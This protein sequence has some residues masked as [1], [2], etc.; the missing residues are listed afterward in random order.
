MRTRTSN[1][2]VVIQYTDHGNVR[3]IDSLRTPTAKLRQGHARRAMEEFIAAADAEGLTLE[4]GAS[5]LNKSTSLGRLVRFYESLG[6]RQTGRSVNPAGHPLMRRAPVASTVERLYASRADVPSQLGSLTVPQANYWG[7]IYDA[8]LARDGDTAKAARIAWFQTRARLDRYGRVPAVERLPAGQAEPRGEHGPVSHE[9][10]VVR[11]HVARVRRWAD[12]WVEDW[13][14]PR[15]DNEAGGGAVETREDELERMRAWG[16]ARGLRFLGAGVS[17]AVYALDARYVVKFAL[18][19]TANMNEAA[20]WDAAPPDV[21]KFLMPVVDS[22]GD[23]LIMA[24]APGDG[25]HTNLRDASGRL[26]VIVPLAARTRLQQFG[27]EDIEGH[28]TD[29]FST[30]GR[31]LDYGEW[32]PRP[33][34]VERLR[35]EPLPTAAHS[36]AS[37]TTAWARERQKINDDRMPIMLPIDDLVRVR[38]YAWTRE[39]AR[40]SPAEWDALVESMR[41]HGWDPK[42][43]AH[44]MVGKDGRAKLG[45]GNH[46]LAIARRLGI[47]EVPVWVHFYTSVDGGQRVVGPE[48]VERMGLAVPDGVVEFSARWSPVGTLTRAARGEDLTDDLPGIERVRDARDRAYARAREAIRRVGNDEAPVERLYASRADLPPQLGSLTVPQANY[49]SKVYDAVKEREVD[50]GASDREAGGKAAAI[51]WY[52]TR[53]RLAEHGRVPSV[54]RMAQTRALSPFERG[55]L[56]DLGFASDPEEIDLDH[57]WR[58]VADDPRD[59]AAHI[60][61]KRVLTGQWHC[62][63]R[64][65]D[66]LVRAG[67]HPWYTVVEVLREVDPT[68]EIEDPPKPEG[69]P[70]A[71]DA[72]AVERMAATSEPAWLDLDTVLAAVPAAAANGVSEVARSRRGFVAAYR[73]ADGDPNALARDGHSGQDWRARRNAFV[74]RH[75]AQGDAEGYWSGGAPTRRHLALVMWAYSP[76]PKRLRAWLSGLG[77]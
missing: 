52:Q 67:V 16:E 28:R 20:A 48:E 62:H 35:G 69:M 9:D 34:R 66:A 10:P 4:L 50:A 40:N 22:D 41:V 42:R 65:V 26:R 53:K 46:R 13:V 1:A 59:Y 72:F 21:R 71:R 33:E 18:D 15:D 68:G 76:D 60:V 7:R 70:E 6:F 73:D 36:V 17:R 31:V 12:E 49:W 74:A 75:T 3:T 55:V 30:D 32:W 63:G 11:A 5:P 14:E 37:I 19:P 23:W 45:E 77:R 57:A 27:I 8:V 58:H 29:N 25:R 2:G 61:A 51:A 47:R 38:E 54:E 43:P 39:H 24:R 64:E 44:L 56:V